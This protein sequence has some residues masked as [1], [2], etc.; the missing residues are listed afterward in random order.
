MD[1]HK[2]G[3]HLVATG[4][5]KTL[6]DIT[7]ALQAMLGAHVESARLLKALSECSRH[8]TDGT[9]DAVID[10]GKPV[11]GADPHSVAFGAASQALMLEMRALGAALR[12][13]RARPQGTGGE[14]STNVRLAHDAVAHAKLAVW[15]ALGRFFDEAIDTRVERR[16][17]A[18][19]RGEASASRA[20][21]K[22]LHD[23][24]WREVERL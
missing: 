15:L 1:V 20:T 9:F 16:L 4:L 24:L 6:A 23:A 10:R 19:N 8:I 5:A 22:R 11:L 14:L 17:A 13:R 21:L 3:D 7:A 12:L 2:R 18:M